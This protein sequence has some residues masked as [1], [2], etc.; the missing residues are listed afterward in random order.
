MSTYE[1]QLAAAG[2]GGHEAK[3]PAKPAATVTQSTI[4]PTQKVW[5]FL[6]ST[7]FITALFGML[8]DYGIEVPPDTQAF[9]TVVLVFAAM[10]ATPN[11]AGE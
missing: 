5:A 6:S 11:K 1:E 4:F 3:I 8:A 10:W 2:I 7:G 9:V